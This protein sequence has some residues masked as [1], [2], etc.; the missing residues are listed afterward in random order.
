MKDYL[1]LPHI[2]QHILAELRALNLKTRFSRELQKWLLSLVVLGIALV[3][4]PSVSQSQILV[5]GRSLDWNYIAG[6]PREEAI[7]LAY[8]PEYSQYQLGILNLVFRIWAEEDPV[9]AYD[10]LLSLSNDFDKTLIETQIIER[11]M[12]IDPGSAMAAAA[13][14]E[15]RQTFELALRVYAHVD[16]VA[17]LALAQGYGPRVGEAAWTGIVEGVASSNPELAAQYVATLGPDGEYLVDAFI[18]ALAIENPATALDWLL[19]HFPR[20]TRHYDSVA[21]FFYIR[22]PIEAFAYLDQMDDGVAKDAFAK[23]LYQAKSVNEASRAVSG[24][25]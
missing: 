6:L 16:P 8:S 17:A 9:K 7:A 21:S 18:A 23:A 22:N 10:R 15:S 1:P 25:D 24:L 12:L 14:S 20:Q 13:N 5:S 4:W 11:W 2:P 3:V 19:E